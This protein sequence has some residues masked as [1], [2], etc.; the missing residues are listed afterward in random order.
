[1]G[2]TPQTFLQSLAQFT[3]VLPEILI[4]IW[5]TVVLAIEVTVP[6]IK[7]R[8][9]GSVAAGGA[10]AAMVVALLLAPSAQQNTAIFGGMLRD[11]LYASVFRVIL[12]AGAAFTCLASIDFKPMR[13]GGEYYALVLFSAMSMSLMAASSDIIM[14]FLATET[15]SLAQYLLAGFQRG[16]KL[17]AE[18]GIK[19]F[20][21]GVVAST[22]MLYGL[23]LIYGFSGETSYTAIMPKLTDQALRVP[24]TFALL[25]VMAGF[26]FK[27][28]AVPFHFWAPDVY[29]GAPSPVT[30]FISTASKAAGF[31]IL[32]RF[33]FYTF[34]PGISA[35]A[36]T[37]VSLMQPITIMTMVVGN[38]LA[39]TQS[40]I[41]RM[42]A[43]S[44]IAQA[45]YIL[46]GVTAFASSGVGAGDRANTLAAI[47]FYIA[48]YMLTNIAAFAVVSI[49]AQKIGSDEIKDYAGL[50]RR[51]F[52]LAL[53]MVAALLSLA[54][55]PPLVGF[56]GKLF[57]FRAAIGDGLYALVAIGVIMVLVSVFYYLGI[58]RAM[59]AERAD[60][61]NRPLAM[62]SASA[63]VI[64]LTGMGVVVTTVL[65]APFWD[66]ALSAA[67]S[68]LAKN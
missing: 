40:N 41:K 58:V 15:S 5:A 36:Q 47:I 18:A 48:T 11:D 19:Y 68:F 27:T 62:P 25:L 17:S 53:G 43:Y 65:V 31:A 44:S 21:F 33:M 50:S 13:A 59:F 24:V 66:M 38:L 57:L 28:S 23:S 22:V 30:G 8:T 49:V 42:L 26:A 29:Q 2:S 46:I 20:V 67:K 61:D 14:L 37:W 12:Y 16:N 6:G 35:A 39:I 1:M 3:P 4:T 60:S 45:G 10:V 52:F 32:I 51:N 64:L 9:L 55:A 56:L 34:E 7:R 54:G 63:A